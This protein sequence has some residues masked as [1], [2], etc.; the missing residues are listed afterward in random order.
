M[1]KRRKVFIENLIVYGLAGAVIYWV[2]RGI[3]LSHAEIVLKHANLAV[4]LP[5]GLLAFAIWF[6]GEVVLFATLFSYFHGEN[7]YRDVLPAC[8]ALYFLQAVN[9]LAAAGALIV[10][11]NRK[12]NVK[13][14]TATMT[15]AFAGFIDGIVLALLIVLAG[16]VVPSS[17][18]RIF[19]PYAAGVLALLCL[20]ACWWMWRTPGTQFERWLYN[21]PSLV[22]FREARLKHYLQLGLIRFGIFLPQG[23]LYYVEI[24]SFG[25]RVPLTQV[26]ALTPVI[27][28]AGSEPMTPVGLGPV[29]VAMVDGFARYVRRSTMLVL[30]ISISLISLSGRL[31]L[32]IASAGTF[33]ESVLGL[34]EGDGL[35]PGSREPSHAPE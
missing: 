22:S 10:Y 3:S 4:F 7:S 1:S 9:I 14:A 12:R 34:G 26:L 15:V 8:A 13:W 16:I 30:S 31:L 28:L 29:Q 24:L 19:L 18:V 23:L 2:G 35:P 17:P 5:A 6:F 33:T 11:L 32:G 21:R 27:I 20:I 25:A